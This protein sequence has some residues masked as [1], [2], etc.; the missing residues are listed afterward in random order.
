MKQRTT[1]NKEKEVCKGR[2]RRKEY[3]KTGENDRKRKDR[4][5]ERTGRI[6]R[7]KYIKVELGE[8]NTRNQE[9]IKETER[10]CGAL[11]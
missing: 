7:M 4:M 3:E 5:K 8:R 1:T 9:K 11:S 6:K 2:I 10:N